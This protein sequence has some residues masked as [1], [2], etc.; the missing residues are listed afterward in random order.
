[1]CVCIPQTKRVGKS[2]PGRYAGA[3]T[4]A[5]SPAR[6]WRHARRAYTLFELVLVLA[7]LVVLAA[8][9]LPSM[10]AMYG[11][12]RLAAAADMVRAN[13]A[14]ARAHALDEGRPYRFAIVPNHGNFRIAPD[15][16][17]FWGSANVPDLTESTEPPLV[18]EDVLPRGVRFTSPDALQSGA[19]DLS[20]DAVL[21]PGSIDPSMW[22]RTVTFL[23]DGTTNEDVEIAFHGR[24]GQPV[25]LKLRAL[26]GVVTMKSIAA[27]M[28]R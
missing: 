5:W 2:R 18:L 4:P 20:G 13:W 10:D 7:V 1:M 8:F 22:S 23:P 25:V 21:S 27:E 19:V 3:T 26:T 28:H 17:D 12:F 16:G 15:S 6:G 14:A 24:G 11:N 9:T